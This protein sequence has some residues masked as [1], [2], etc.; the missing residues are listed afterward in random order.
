MPVS[1]RDSIEL[2]IMKDSDVLLEYDQVYITLDKKEQDKY[3]GLILA[4]KREFLKRY[5]TE[6]EAKQENSR[7]TFKQNINRINSEF[8][9]KN[10]EGW[11]TDRGRIILKLGSP[12]KRDIETYNNEY[13]DH[14]IWTYFTG[15]YTFVFADSHGLGD[16]KLVHSDYP[17]E[18]SD[19][20][21][22]TKIKKSDF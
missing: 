20:N 21:W 22:Q 15:N 3:T 19:P 11:K 1:S 13:S 2:D 14:E 12:S 4:G 8:S 18:K 16:F 10:T 7:E 5:W 9:T 6:Q 17:G